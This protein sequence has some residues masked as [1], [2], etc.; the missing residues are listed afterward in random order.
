[1]GIGVEAKGLDIRRSPAPSS[2]ETSQFTEATTPVAV[3]DHHDRVRRG[4]IPPRPLLRV[5]FR[6]VIGAPS[7][8]PAR[9]YHE[10]DS[11]RAHL[12]RLHSLSAWMYR[13]PS[14][15]GRLSSRQREGDC[16]RPYLEDI[17]RPR[18]FS[19]AYIADPLVVV[20]HLA[21]RRGGFSVS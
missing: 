19:T 2:S 1:L 11:G 12:R 20:Q 5:R 8:C 7:R 15:L 16:R 9:S 21:G 6:R 14:A 3:R 10:G 4:A 18:R 17:A 13:F